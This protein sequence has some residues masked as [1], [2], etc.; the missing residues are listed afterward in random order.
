MQKENLMS[1][2]WRFDLAINDSYNT[3]AKRKSNV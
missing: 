1:K 3:N 2:Y